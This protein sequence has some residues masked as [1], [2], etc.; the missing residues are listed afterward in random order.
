MVFPVFFDGQVVVPRLSGIP[1]F[2]ASLWGNSEPFPAFV[3][4]VSGIL[5][6]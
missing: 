6:P 5:F 3:P 2:R 1:H 4:R